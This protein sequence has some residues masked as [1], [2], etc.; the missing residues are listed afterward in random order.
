M[1]ARGPD[2]GVTSAGTSAAPSDR[3][4]PSMDSPDW[5]AAPAPFGGPLPTSAPTP[6][7]N[8]PDAPFSSGPDVLAPG[9]SNRIL[10]ASSPNYLAAPL[11][12]GGGAGTINDPGM[13]YGV[14]S[15]P[16]VEIGRPRIADSNWVD[17][18][19]TYLGNS[20]EALSR[21]PRGFLDIGRDLVTDPL[22]FLQR[23]GPGLAGVTGSI[24]FVGPVARLN[25]RVANGATAG[26]RDA[27]AVADAPAILGRGSQPAYGSYPPASSFVGS[28]RA[29]L[30]ATAGPPRN[31]PGEFNGVPYSGHAFDQM[32]NR[33]IPPHVV[34]RAVRTGIG[35]PGKEPG[36]TRYYDPVN[37]V[38]VIRDNRTGNVI[39]LRSGD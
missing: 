29:P 13:N 38:S 33:G 18:I 12:F 39:T 8:G 11:P 31:S 2:L 7:A 4:M 25:A 37:N 32:Q 26:G 35:R 24:P 21:A 23:A 3:A 6:L 16:G 19:G 1:N 36:T 9:T 17:E 20:A 15:D 28:Q 10:P 30:Q 34:D 27:A 22:L 14:A 5:V